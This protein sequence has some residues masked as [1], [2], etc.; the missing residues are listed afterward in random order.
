MQYN[1]RIILDNHHYWRIRLTLDYGLFLHMCVC[2][3]NF[4]QNENI[5]IIWYQYHIQTI[6][7]S[8]MLAFISFALFLP[9]TATIN[10]LFG[11]I[12]LVSN[13]IQITHTHTSTRIALDTPTVIYIYIGM[14]S[15]FQY[16]NSKFKFKNYYVRYHK[17]YT[18]NLFKTY[19]CPTWLQF[20]LKRLLLLLF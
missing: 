17:V 5:L 13:S 3:C 20:F 9:L 16:S 18:K 12:R 2:V 7:H 10:R 4:D 11:A 6:M 1:C 8:K 19:C 15:K 14:P